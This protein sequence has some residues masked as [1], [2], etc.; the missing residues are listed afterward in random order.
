MIWVARYIYNLTILPILVSFLCLSVDCAR[1]SYSVTIQIYRLVMF[2]AVNE[3]TNTEFHCIRF[4]YKRLN[5]NPTQ[6]TNCK[7]YLITFT[8]RR[9][10]YTSDHHVRCLNPDGPSTQTVHF[11][12]R[13]GRALIFL[14]STVYRLDGIMDNPPT[15]IT[16]RHVTFDTRLPTGPCDKSVDHISIQPL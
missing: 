2:H 6:L 7:L 10:S 11:I 9:K 14:Q 1:W 15:R 3:D 12:D 4:S 5:S 8:S 16:R 13:T